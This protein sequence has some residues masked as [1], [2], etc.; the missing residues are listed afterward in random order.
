M[1]I[2]RGAPAAFAVA[3]VSLAP[4]GAE[5]STHA[6]INTVEIGDFIGTVIIETARRSDVRL[7]N[8]SG[9]LADYPVRISAENGV[10]TI[11]SDEDPDDTR[12]WDDVNWRRYEG[13]AFEEFLKDYP[14]LTL[15]I[16]AGA[17]LAF[18]SAVVRLDAG[19]TNGALSVREGH[20]DGVIGDIASGDI[21]IHG[22]GDLKTGAVAGPLNISIYGSGDFEALAAAS[23]NTS[24]NGSGDIKIGAIGG[25]VEAGIHGSGD[26][27]LGD[28]D[29]AM[30]ASIKGSGDIHADRVSGGAA[31][32]IYGSGDIAVASVNG[33]TTARIHGSGD[34]DIRDGRAENLR[35][36]I[37]GSGGFDFGGLATNPDIEADSSGDVRI[38][39]HEGSVRAR[40]D[41]DIRISGIQYGDD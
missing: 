38:R 35:V 24:I 27:L 30:I 10:L 6:N 23:L 18:D 17:A 20:V 31:V 39:R 22:S 28:I 13:K 15:T 3:M 32:S 16:P 12:W 9:A 29:G 40:G 34:I 25:D 36:A 33:E 21:K 41:G 7:D 11:R 5:Q 19:D 26:I 37:H 2:L 1:R 8:R 4:A 14:T